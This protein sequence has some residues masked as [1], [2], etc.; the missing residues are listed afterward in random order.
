VYVADGGGGSSTASETFTGTQRL[1]IQPSAIPAALKAFSDAYD[2]V[3]KKVE[4]LRGLPIREWAQDPVSGETAVVFTQRTNGGGAESAIACLTGYQ[5]QL[6][7]AIGSL[8]S[9]HD[10]YLRVEGTNYE[11][12]GHYDRA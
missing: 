6:E 5:K 12:W 7:R 4:E 3:S 2:R 9:A 10:T 8:K 1:H 11:R